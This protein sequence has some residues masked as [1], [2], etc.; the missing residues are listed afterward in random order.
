MSNWFTKLL[1]I[2]KKIINGITTTTTTTTAIIPPIQNGILKGYGMVNYWMTLGEFDTLML[3]LKNNGC[4]CTS[5]E[6]FGR[7]EEGW[8]NKQDILKNQFAKLIA[9][10]RKHGIIVFIDMVNQGSGSLTSQPNSWFQE[11]LNFIKSFGQANMV[12]QA[13]GE[14]SGDKSAN[15]YV[16]MENTLNGFALSW[17]MGTRPQTASE[18]Y[19]YIDYHSTTLTDLGGGDKRI[20]DNTDSGILSSMMNGGVMGQTFKVDQVKTFATGALN[21]G[22]SVNLYGYA[23]KSIDVEAIKALGKCGGSNPNPDPSNDATET[24]MGLDV[25]KIQVFGSQDP[26]NAKMTVKVTN[27]GLNNG[28]PA[29]SLQWNKVLGWKMY[30]QY[31]DGFLMVVWKRSTSWLSQYLEWKPANNLGYN[32]SNPLENMSQSP[33]PEELKAQNGDPCGFFILS[34]DKIERSNTLF[35]KWPL[36]AKVGFFKRMMRGIKAKIFKG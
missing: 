25:S 20:I 35:D 31:C 22:K 28:S 4:N 18:K 2:I 5:I 9:S 27:L 10:A 16:M 29:V 13:V 30:D 8:I 11:W 32:W 7:E 14:G 19:K 36:G 33:V 3:T 12:V 24:S 21:A 15:W 17:N 26:R 23:H 6:I 1:E 34:S